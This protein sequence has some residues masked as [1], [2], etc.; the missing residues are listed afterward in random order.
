MRILVCSSIICIESWSRLSWLYAEVRYGIGYQL[1]DLSSS[2][3]NQQFM[4]ISSIQTDRTC[5]G[6]WHHNIG[7]LDYLAKKCKP[8]IILII[9]Y[10][11]RKSTLCFVESRRRCTMRFCCCRLLTYSLKSG[12]VLKALSEELSSE[13]EARKKSAP[14]WNMYWSYDKPQNHGTRPRPRHPNLIITRYYRLFIND[15]TFLRHIQTVKKLWS[16][17]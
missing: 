14:F 8:F 5:S 3:H 6:H 9:H 2:A 7:T 12:T 13:S 1:V 4:E 15:V 17:Q 16:S 11:E 10:G